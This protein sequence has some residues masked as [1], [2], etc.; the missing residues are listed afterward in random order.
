M[1]QSLCQPVAALELGMGPESSTQPPYIP[2]R[3]CGSRTSLCHPGWSSP[4]TQGRDSVRRVAQDGMAAS[5]GLWWVLNMGPDHHPPPVPPSSS[6]QVF[7]GSEIEAKLSRGRQRAKGGSAAM[8]G[9]SLPPATTVE[10]VPG[11]PSTC[12][13][14]PKIEVLPPRQPSGPRKP[15]DS[16]RPCP[17][18]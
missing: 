12:I 15:P 11:Q 4:P 9:G 13:H 8:V 1:G 5:L 14:P 3:R 10:H 7:R 17:A 2:P 16:G 18:P 6:H